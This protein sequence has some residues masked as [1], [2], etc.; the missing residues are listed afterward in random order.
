MSRVLRFRVWDSHSRSYWLPAFE[1][2]PHVGSRGLH[3]TLDGFPVGPGGTAS[4]P[5]DQ[6][7]IV[8]QFTGILS[9][10]ARPIY[11]GDIL[12]GEIADGF[13][14]KSPHKAGHFRVEWGEWNHGW[15]MGCTMET[16]R[17][18]FYPSFESCEVVGNVH[19][20]IDLLSSP[21]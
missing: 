14:P 17:W 2:L 10:S 8:E 11:E 1:Q 16:S 15:V 18:R 13:S 19:E 12:A 5:L 6:L 3:L 4:Y 9:K 7:P 20:N 21:S